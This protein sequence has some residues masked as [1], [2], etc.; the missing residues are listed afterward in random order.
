MAVVANQAVAF[1]KSM[2][3]S[4]FRNLERMSGA[5]RAA[6]QAAILAGNISNKI[7]WDA[8][9]FSLGISSY[10]APGKSKFDVLIPKHEGIPTSKSDN[11]TTVED[12][13]TAI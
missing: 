13:Q 4:P 10:V 9:P 6:I 12:N 5:R 7:V 3:T 2:L 1:D 8:F 11:Y